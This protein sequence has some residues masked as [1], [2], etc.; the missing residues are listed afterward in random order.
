M[1]SS[2]GR[3]V[4]RLT[5]VSVLVALVVSAPAA[6]PGQRDEAGVVASPP[7]TA[8]SASMGTR[9]TAGGTPAAARA[10]TN[11]ASVE[12]A[13][14]PAL[15]DEPSPSA[16]AAEP[17]GISVHPDDA[18]HRARVREAIGRFE[19]AGLR[20]PVVLIEFSDDDDACDGHLGLFDRSSQPWAVHVCS[21]LEFVLTHELGHAWVATH[22]DDA[23]REAYVA[24]RGLAG[25]NDRDL[26]WMERG[27]EDAAYVLQQVLMTEH[28][29][30]DTARWQER[31]AAYQQL[32]GSP[33]PQEAQRPVPNISSCA[34]RRGCPDTR[35][36][37]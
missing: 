37:E 7:V 26:D 9:R 21:D 35:A 10:Q 32:T 22:L 14:G 31:S 28:P 4:L 29:R 17:S 34:L 33:P 23:D 24:F 3:R 2:H 1:S 15:T 16:R 30:L 13:R 18:D 11:R 36:C 25:W 12:G 5:V 6:R 27:T 20:L 8:T 19:D